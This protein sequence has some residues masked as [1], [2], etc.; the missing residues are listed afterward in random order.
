TKCYNCG[1]TGHFARDCTNEAQERRERSS[2]CYHCE[3]EG[4]LARD[5]PNRDTKG[6]GGGDK[7]SCYNCN[8]PG[9]IARDCPDG[10]RGGGGGGGGR[11]QTCYK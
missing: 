5:C 11:E 8:R 2:A 1:K 6:G 10:R 7:G 9:H 3:E 4:H